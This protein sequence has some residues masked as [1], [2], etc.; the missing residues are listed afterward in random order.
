MLFLQ[1]RPGL[2][3]AVACLCVFALGCAQRT[4]ERDAVASN[5]AQ[6]E[7]LGYQTLA[8]IGAGQGLALHEGFAYVFGDAETG[9]IREYSILPRPK[10]LSP[11]GRVV[12]L[13]VNGEDIAPHPT[14]LTFHTE[15]GV[16]LGDT[17]RRRGTL[18]F[19]DWRRALNTG[20]LDG[21][22]LAT[23][24][25]DAAINGTRPEFV[26]Y[27][28]RDYVATSDYG[29]AG[30]EI[31]LYDPAALRVA[32]RTSDPGVLAHRFRCGPWVQ[33][34]RWTPPDGPLLLVQNQI[35]GLR[36]RLTFADLESTI[37]FRDAPRVDMDE[38]TN[39]LQGFATLPD[40]RLL[41]INASSS[42]NAVI[43]RWAGE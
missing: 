2:V 11:T 33:S 8:G 38:P 26:R 12:R 1:F 9:V 15:Y 3:P 34:L 36:Y 27:L 16:L 31:R 40:G 30:N 42:N 20:T 10:P 22:V 29:D 7:V 14:G 19:I 13:T 5:P 39:E 6:I 24:D 41:L 23:I 17:V 43:A 18:F 32:T 28:G 37:D 4:P 25:D 21:A 35:E